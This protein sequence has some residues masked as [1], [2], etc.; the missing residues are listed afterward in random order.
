MVDAFESPWRPRAAAERGVGA[1]RGAA[2]ERAGAIVAAPEAAE[3][4]EDL[5]AAVMAYERA[6]LLAALERCRHNQRRTAKALGLSYDQ[7]RH[8]MKR[9]GLLGAEVDG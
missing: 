3:V 6:L 4:V 7:L 1:E 2:A 5:R 9:H 8:C